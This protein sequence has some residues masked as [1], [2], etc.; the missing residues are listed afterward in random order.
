MCV[1]LM[2]KY[3][4]AHTFTQLT[5]AI[6][7]MRDD[8]RGK[9]ANIRANSKFTKTMLTFV[10]QRFPANLKKADT[11][12]KTALIAVRSNITSVPREKAKRK[13]PAR[14]PAPRP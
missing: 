5:S 4:N 14:V 1:V 13:H 10:F 2:D 12:E 8:V 3:M 7:E 6:Q 9:H 11:S